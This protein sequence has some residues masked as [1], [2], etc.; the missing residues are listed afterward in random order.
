[1]PATVDHADL[2]RQQAVFQPQPDVQPFFPLQADL[3]Q[4]QRTQPAETGL[5][6]FFF[7]DGKFIAFQFFAV[8][9]V[10]RYR[11]LIQGLLRELVEKT[12]DVL[13]LFGQRHA[14]AI[15]KRQH[16]FF[17]GK[18]R[19]E[20]FLAL[21]GGFCLAVF[22]GAQPLG[23]QYAAALLVRFILED[24]RDAGGV[25]ADPEGVALVVADLQA[26]AHF[27]D[28]EIRTLV[29]DESELRVFGERMRGPDFFCR[30]VYRL[31]DGRRLRLG[32]DLR[33]F[34]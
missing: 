14:V 30:L 10:H 16:F 11:A 27:A 2:H 4:R 12:D 32:I 31:I 5:D 15:Q 20:R 3:A 24:A 23:R 22:D 25:H 8:A 33:L 26:V 29:G 1:L 28:C 19:F 21:G 18:F 13:G 6:H 7:A 34:R 17:P 9:D